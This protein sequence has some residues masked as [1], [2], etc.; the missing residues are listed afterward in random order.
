MTNHSSSKH[1]WDMRCYICSYIIVV[2]FCIGLEADPDAI[3]RIVIKVWL[4]FV[5]ARRS[6]SILTYLD[7]MC[8]S[9]CHVGIVGIYITQFSTLLIMY[10]GIVYKDTWIEQGRVNAC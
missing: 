5:F 1:I 4:G 3:D 2:I 9:S 6:V 8:T 7:N 10:D